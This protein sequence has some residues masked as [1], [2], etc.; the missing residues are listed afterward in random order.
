MKLE[1]EQYEEIKRTVIDTFLEYGVRS[2]LI[3]AFE[4]AT[5]MGLSVMP[6]SAL[7]EPQRKVAL[8]ISRDGFSVEVD[9]RTWI[10]YYNDSCKNY[11]R[12]NHTIMHEI[13]HYAMGHTEKGEEEEKE[14]EAKFFA[15]YAL[16]PPPLIHQLRMPIDAN[17]IMKCFDISY[18]AACYAYKYYIRWLKFG[19]DEYTDYELKMLDLF[20]V[21]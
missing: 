4:M 2:I 3:S 21:A 1:N 15:K 18:E 7:N 13:G 19:G 10:I 16:A 6:Y 8:K 14:T 12:I 17:I 9:S 20:N 11:G 5:K